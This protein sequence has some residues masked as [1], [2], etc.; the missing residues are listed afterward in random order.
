MKMLCNIISISVLLLGTAHADEVLSIGKCLDI[1]AG[2]N[3]LDH[4]DDPST[5]KPKQYKLGATRSTI[6]FNI[7]A[8]RHITEVNDTIKTGLIAEIGGGKPPQAFNAAEIS[9]LNEE[10]KKILDAP[11]DTKPAHIKISDLH[12]GDGPDENAIP[13]NVIAALAPI[14]DQ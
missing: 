5:G 1:A 9:K 8:L 7:A 4:Y 13:P 2:L 14:L 6:G 10:Y 11:C 12:L 3:A